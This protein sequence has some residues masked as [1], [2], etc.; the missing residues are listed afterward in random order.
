MTA[1][2]RNITFDSIWLEIANT[3]RHALYVHDNRFIAEKHRD[4]YAENCGDTKRR[5]EFQSKWLLEDKIVRL[6]PQI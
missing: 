1:G 5:E 6:T 2:S 4:R 3:T